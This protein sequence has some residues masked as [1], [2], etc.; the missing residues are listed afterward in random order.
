MMRKNPSTASARPA[1]RRLSSY[2][3]EIHLSPTQTEELKTWLALA[4]DQAVNFNGSQAAE[5]DLIESLDAVEKIFALAARQNMPREKIETAMINAVNPP[6]ETP[7]TI[8]EFLAVASLFYTRLETANDFETTLNILER[9]GVPVVRN[10]DLHIPPAA[11]DIQN[12]T[13]DD[14]NTFKIETQPRLAWLIEGLKAKGLY[15]SDIMIT[16]G[17]TPKNIVRRHPYVIIDIPYVPCQIAVC[18]Q[19]GER[20]FISDKIYEMDFWRGFNKELLNATD[21]VT[22]FIC[23]TR[24]QWMGDIVDHITTLRDPSQ[25]RV[26]MKAFAAAPQRT[27]MPITIEAIRDSILA[28]YEASSE[29]SEKRRYPAINHGTVKHGALKGQITWVALN[30]RFSKLKHFP[31]YSSLADFMAKQGYKEN[32]LDIIY[33]SLDDIRDSTSATFIETGEYPLH[34]DGVIKHGILKNKLKW[35]TVYSRFASRIYEGYISFPD[36]LEK[37]GFKKNRLNPAHYSLEEIRQSLIISFEK[38]KRW[39]RVDEG[40]IHHGPL[41][42]KTKWSTLDSRFKNGWYKEYTHLKDFKKQVMAEYEAG[43]MQTPSPPLTP[44]APAP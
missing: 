18:D 40:M 4:F 37:E 29:D 26:D 28:T 33:I 15:T 24:A 19:V 13:S 36:F 6:P 22:G 20:T 25:V 14:P 32:H 35:S 3:L 1:S 7:R 42:N 23:R 12:A 39:P 9:A 2:G 44:P 8:Y 31:E 38:T 34:E 17:E 11:G 27:K 5:E 10:N 30:Q 41:A 16:V 43:Q 21:G